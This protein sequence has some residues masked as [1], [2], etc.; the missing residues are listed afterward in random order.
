MI[1]C[2]KVQPRKR[3]NVYYDPKAFRL[4]IFNDDRE[5]LLDETR[6]LDQIQSLCQ[7]PVDAN[8]CRLPPVQPD[9]LCRQ[10]PNKAGG[11]RLAQTFP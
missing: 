1:L 8:R 10:L 7:I 6:P 4:C 3:Q 5:R 2:F 11:C 9:P